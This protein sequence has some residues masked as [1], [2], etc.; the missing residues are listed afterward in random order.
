MILKP[1]LLYFGKDS[2]CFLPLSKN[3]PDT[4]M[5]SK[6]QDSLVLTVLLGLQWANFCRSIMNRCKVSKE[7][8]K[9]KMYSLI[10]STRNCKVTKSSAQGDKNCKEKP[11]AT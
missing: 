9:H 4:K 7:K 2:D 11:D 3:L 10:R 5:K 6:F 8:K 1:F